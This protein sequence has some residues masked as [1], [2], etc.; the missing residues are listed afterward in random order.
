MNNT[1]LIKRIAL[2]QAAII[3]F[4]IILVIQ[5]SVRIEVKKDYVSVFQSPLE[6]A[7]EYDS[8]DVRF[9]ELLQKFPQS[10]FHR[11]QFGNNSILSDCALLRKTNYARILIQHGADVE[12]AIRAS[13][14]REDDEAV[15]MLRQLQASV[16][17]TTNLQQGAV[18]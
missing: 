3:L 2:L 13:T 9:G 11:S 15:Q 12:E 14:K 1:R 17:V 6:L 7:L 10:I 16:V 5:R 8:S 4:L 18:R